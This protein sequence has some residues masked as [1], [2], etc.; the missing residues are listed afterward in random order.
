[1]RELHE[2]DPEMQLAQ[3]AEVMRAGGAVAATFTPWKLNYACYGNSEP[4]LHWHIFP[5]REDDPNRELPPWADWEQFDA[6]RIGEQEAR[7][8]ASRLRAAL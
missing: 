7:T 2:L 6:H 1:M 5:R 3:F 4:H 8:L